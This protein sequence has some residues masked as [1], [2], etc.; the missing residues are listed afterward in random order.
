MNK[1]KLLYGLKKFGLF[2][3]IFNTFLIISFSLFNTG[4]IY[5]VTHPDG[6]EVDYLINTVDCT[7]IKNVNESFLVPMKYQHSQRVYTERINETHGKTCWY[8]SYKKEELNT[9]FLFDICEFE[10]AENKFICDQNFE[11]KIK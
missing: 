10:R 11:V 5:Q 6:E 4:E 3:I 1:E 9:S 2:F 8:D 7:E